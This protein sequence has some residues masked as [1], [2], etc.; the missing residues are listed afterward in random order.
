[1]GIRVKKKREEL[2]FQERLKEQVHSYK[3]V[4]QELGLLVTLQLQIGLV[5]EKVIQLV[6]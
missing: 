1:M 3:A 5:T 6:N 2:Q 4:S